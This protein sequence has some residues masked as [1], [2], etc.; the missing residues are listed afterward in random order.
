MVIK[1]GIVGF[2]SWGKRHFQSWK[3]VP[4]TEVVGIYDPAYRQESH[5]NLNELIQRVDAL[6]IVVPAQ[7]LAQV[8]TQAVKAGKHFFLE[9]PVA[10][11]V[12]EAK[13]LAGLANSRPECLSMVGFIERFNPV[14]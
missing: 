1:V 4:N 7:S 12:V 10:T 9:K 11:N 3:K 13:R 2:G 8:G 6:D 5:S 14:F